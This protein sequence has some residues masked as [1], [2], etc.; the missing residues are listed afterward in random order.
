MKK[1]DLG[2]FKKDLKDIGLN[3]EKAEAISLLI[4]EAYEK[5][6]KDGA[7]QFAKLAGLMYEK[8]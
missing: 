1:K 8:N 6:R 4:Q 7:N 5:G 3:A 2:Q